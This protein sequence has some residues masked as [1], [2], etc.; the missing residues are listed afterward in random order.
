MSGARIGEHCNLGQNVNVAG[1]AVLGSGVKVQNNVSI[2]DG[3]ET[4]DDVFLGPSCVLTNVKNPRAA[5]G[6]RS[7]FEKTRLR[8]GATVGANATIL[9]GVTLGRH[10]FVAAGAVVTKNVPDYA[11]VVGS[12]A[13][14]VGYMSRH[15]RRL[16]AGPD[17]VMVCPEGGLRYREIEPGILRCLDLSEDAPL[18]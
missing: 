12:P 3:V 9:C 13:R 18:T 5:L 6:R 16:S 4:E 11:L 17:G 7:A 15:G 2:Y 10:S 14:Q 1:G 8:R